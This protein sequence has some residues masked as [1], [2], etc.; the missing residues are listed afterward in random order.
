MLIDGLPRLCCVLSTGCQARLPV[1]FFY[2]LYLLTDQFRASLQHTP[3][4]HSMGDLII[5]LRS[6]GSW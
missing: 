3:D 4:I 2:S 1:L 5:P 6:L